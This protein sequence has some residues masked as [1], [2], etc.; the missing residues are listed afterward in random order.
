MKKTAFVIASVIAAVAVISGSAFAASDSRRPAYASSSA[1]NHDGFVLSADASVGSLLEKFHFGAGIHAEAPIYMD[2][3]RFLFGAKTG[4]YFG[5]S[6]PTSW[7]I[8]FLATG[9]Y[10]LKSS[11]NFKPYFGAGIGVSIAHA[12]G[13]S[14][15]FAFQ[16]DP[17]IGFGE[18]GKYYIELPLGTMAKNFFILPSIGVHF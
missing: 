7:V 18:G 9:T 15:N 16:V 11:G 12:E 17:G 4:F 8:P 13:T 10:E 14:T 5:P 1:P 2:G 6:D 3:H